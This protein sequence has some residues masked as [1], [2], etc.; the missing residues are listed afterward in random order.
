[1]AG[2]R[3]LR[4]LQF[5]LETT[6]G[7]N[8]AATTIWRGMG[9]IKDER[10][11]VFPEEDVGI[12]GG[13]DRSYI[14]SYWSELALDAVETTFEQ[15]PYVFEAG[16]QQVQTGSTDTG[17]SGKIYSYAASITSQNTTGTYSWEGWGRSASR[18]VFLWV[19]KTLQP[20]RGWAGCFDDV[21]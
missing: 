21:E 15:V 12:L 5:S 6:A 14:A 7:T 18:R 3:A 19:C 8:V 1:M 17:G 13:T 11:V 10:E 20:V 16:V 4:K 9:V 2:S